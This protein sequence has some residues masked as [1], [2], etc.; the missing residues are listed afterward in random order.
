MYYTRSDPFTR[1]FQRQFDRLARH[2][3]GPAPALDVV[4][5]EADL[6]CPVSTPSS[7]RSPWTAG[8]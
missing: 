7:S 3:F 2:A 4:R 1:D 8:S 6:T 5:H